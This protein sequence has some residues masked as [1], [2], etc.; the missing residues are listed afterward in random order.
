LPSQKLFEPTYIDYGEPHS[1]QNDKDEEANR[2]NSAAEESAIV[3]LNTGNIRPIK[4]A[5]VTCDSGADTSSA[6]LLFR[7]TPF[8]WSD[9]TSLLND[10]PPNLDRKV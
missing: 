9:A 6:F 1:L 2:G 3:P 4:C 7:T 5:S 10:A 8:D